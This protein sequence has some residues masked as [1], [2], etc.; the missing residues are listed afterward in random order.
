[1]IW[2]TRSQGLTIIEVLVAITLL[3]IAAAL[4]S[5]SAVSSIRNNAA[6]GSRTQAT[7]VLNYLGRLVAGADSVL[8]DHPDLAWDY[9]TLQSS[10]SELTTEV[11]RADPDLYRAWIDD[12]GWVGLGEAQMVHYRVHVCWTPANSTEVC[13][14]GDTAGPESAEEDATPAPLPGIG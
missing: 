6:A 12:L 5:T 1:M 11:G 14:A 8:F 13:L 9:G 10:F 3:G 7:Q 2:R 4:I